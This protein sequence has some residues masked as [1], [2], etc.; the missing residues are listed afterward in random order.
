MVTLSFLLP[1][2]RRKRVSPSPCPSPTSASPVSFIRCLCTSPGCNKLVNRQVRQFKEPQG[3]KSFIIHHPLAPVVQREEKRVAHLQSNSPWS[4]ARTPPPA[5]WA[6]RPISARASGGGRCVRRR[7]C[8][9][10]TV[11]YIACLVF[12][13]FFLGGWNGSFSEASSFWGLFFSCFSFLSFLV[14]MLQEDGRQTD[15]YYVPYIMHN[16]VSFFRLQSKSVY[17]ERERV[18]EVC[19][20]QISQSQPY[21]I[22]SSSAG[23]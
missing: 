5:P 13:G 12:E 19:N 2:P 18:C 6:A 15:G 16:L 9:R 22:N 20:H 21:L 10:G 1:A 23:A 11:V 8:R 4:T 14:A 7:G 17:S 3:H